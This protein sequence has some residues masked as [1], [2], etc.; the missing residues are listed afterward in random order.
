MAAIDI[1]RLSVDERLELLG[2]LWDS[3]TAA[4]DALP[5]TDGQRRELD[6]RLDELDRE[7]PSGISWEDAKRNILNRRP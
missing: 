1:N 6:W 7:G 5:L 2:E 4:P 3:L